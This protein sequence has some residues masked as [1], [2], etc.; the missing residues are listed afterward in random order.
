MFLKKF[1]E[2]DYNSS[3]EYFGSETVKWKKDN[4]IKWN[5]TIKYIEKEG[6]YYKWDIKEGKMILYMGNENKYEFTLSNKNDKYYI[7]FLDDSRPGKIER[8]NSNEVN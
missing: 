4:V 7:G 8:M 5:K 6:V 2:D 1:W 3:V